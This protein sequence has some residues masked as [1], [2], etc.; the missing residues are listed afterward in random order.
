MQCNAIQCNAMQCM[1]SNLIWKHMWYLQPFTLWSL[2]TATGNHHSRLA[3]TLPSLVAVTKHEPM[4]LLQTRLSDTGTDKSKRRWRAQRDQD[5]ATPVDL[6]CKDKKSIKQ[7]GA[8]G[9]E[10]T[11]VL[12]EGKVIQVDMRRIREAEQR[13]IVERKLS[14]TYVRTCIHAYIHT[15]NIAKKH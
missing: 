14:D 1:Y 10:V 4:K 9:Q 15:Y 7:T 13:T 3:P 11:G 5:G 12:E 2:N 8:W 6:A